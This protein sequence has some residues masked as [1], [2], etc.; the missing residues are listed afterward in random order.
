MNQLRLL[1]RM[2]E[3]KLTMRV[4]AQ[5]AGV[6]PATLYRWLKADGKTMTLA[7]AQRIKTALDMTNYEAT[8]IFFGR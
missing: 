5:N 2:K 6:H 4:L 8:E 1:K 3:K 7:G